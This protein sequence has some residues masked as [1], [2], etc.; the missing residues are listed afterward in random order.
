M[1]TPGAPPVADNPCLRCGACCASFRVSFYWAEAADAPGGSVPVDLTEPVTPHV[2]CMR[3]TNHQ[4]PHCAALRGQ[5][6]AQVDCAIYPLRSST[7]REFDAWLADGSPDP[8]CQEARRRWQLPPLG[9]R[10]A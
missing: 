1:T 10:R 5:V 2:R 4:T 7:C 3:G 9:P 8:R 6:G